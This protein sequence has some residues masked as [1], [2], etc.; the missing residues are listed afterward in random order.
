[1]SAAAIQSALESATRQADREVGTVTVMANP[2]L[3]REW[4]Q[5]AASN[6]RLNEKAVDRLSRDMLEGRWLLNGESIKFDRDGHLIDGQH[7]LAAIVKSGITVPMLVVFDLD[8]LA[9]QTVDLGVSRTTG[10]IA[11]MAGV[12]NAN[13][14]GAISVALIR[15]HRNREHKWTSSNVPSKTEQLNYMLEHNLLLSQAL[16]DAEEV[17]RAMGAHRTSYGAAAAL[18]RLA[19]NSRPDWLPFHERIGDGAGLTHGDARLALRNQMMRVRKQHTVWEAQQ[20]LAWV[21]KAW[22]AYCQ[23]DQVKVLRF[24]PNMLPMPQVVTVGDQS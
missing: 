13:A 16:Q 20:Q 18:V 15:Y 2:E 4:L 12:K 22:N 3:A 9:Q 7:R 14:K 8:P 23:G 11:S 21:I 24:T 19:G 5:T 10:Q 17:H 6:R 1:M